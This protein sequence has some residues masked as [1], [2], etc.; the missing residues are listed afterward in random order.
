V[1]SGSGSPRTPD[2]VEGTARSSNQLDGFGGIPVAGSTLSAHRQVDSTGRDR[3][4]AGHT[5]PAPQQAATEG[6]ESAG[7]GP[8]AQR[9]S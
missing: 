2:Q 4:H 1:S 8:D 9:I 6:G 7:A 5:I 3:C